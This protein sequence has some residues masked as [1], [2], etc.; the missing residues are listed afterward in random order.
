MLQTNNIKCDYNFEVEINFKKDILENKH[1]AYFL[2]YILTKKIKII[3]SNQI[4][5]EAQKNYKALI[6]SYNNYE[7]T[8]TLEIIEE[9]NYQEK[10]KVLN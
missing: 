9:V 7:D 10:E 8:I 1:L 2:R 5:L 3:N 4:Q 6:K